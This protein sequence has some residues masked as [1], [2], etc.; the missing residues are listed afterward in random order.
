MQSRTTT[1]INTHLKTSIFIPHY[2][3]RSFLP[4]PPL[5]ILSYSIPLFLNVTVLGVRFQVLTAA[6]VKMTTINYQT[7]RILQRLCI[8]HC[9]SA[10]FPYQALERKLTQ[11]TLIGCA[12]LHKINISKSLNFNLVHGVSEVGYRTTP[13]F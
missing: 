5:F 6:S 11:E 7:V 8:V 9:R 2:F 1:A 10:V 3:L 4:P 13:D 12:G